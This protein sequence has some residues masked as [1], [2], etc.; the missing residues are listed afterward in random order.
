MTP[1]DERI[2]EIQSLFRTVN[3]QIAEAA[4]RFA[5]PT[6]QFYCECHDP[7]CGE[8][9]E[10]ALDEYQEVRARPTRFLHVPHHVEQSFERVVARRRGYAIVEKFGRRLAAVVRRLDPR[11]QTATS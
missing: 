3:E 10:V 6:A 1:S 2:G 4:D 5:V 11:A 8:R 7:A 9:L